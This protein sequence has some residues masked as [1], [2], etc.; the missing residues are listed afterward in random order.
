MTGDQYRAT[1]ATLHRWARP[2]LEVDLTTALEQAEPGSAD[3]QFL[4]DIAGFQFAVN[5]HAHGPHLIALP[6]GAG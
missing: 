5:S 3:L 2:L 1:I 4:E 6:G